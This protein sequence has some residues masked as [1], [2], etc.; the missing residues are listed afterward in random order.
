LLI[1]RFRFVA[2]PNDSDIKSPIAN[3][4]HFFNFFEINFSNAII[5]GFLQC[6]RK[7]E[8]QI[9]WILKWLTPP[10]LLEEILTDNFLWLPVSGKRTTY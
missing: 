3:L 5:P 1:C 7:L 2:S 4:S 6:F 10:F 9:F 8:K